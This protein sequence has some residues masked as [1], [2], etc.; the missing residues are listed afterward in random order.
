[1]NWLLLSVIL[2]MV[3]CIFHGYK[4]GLVRMLFSVATFVVTILLVKM[5]AP[6]GVQA[7]KNTDVIYDA[8]K[9]PVEKLL[10]EKID[11]QVF[12]LPGRLRTSG[13]RWFL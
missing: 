10:D 9:A 12:G 5:L 13:N 8:I 4:S 7:M 11:G 2:L 6:V 3:I 1:M